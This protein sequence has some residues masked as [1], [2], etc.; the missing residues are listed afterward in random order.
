MLVYHSPT[1]S[2]VINNLFIDY[3]LSS[4]RQLKTK[5]LPLIVGGDM[6][7]NLLNPYN[8]GYINNFIHGMFELGL[9]PAV[10]IPTKVNKENSVTKFSIIDQF[11]VNSTLHVSNACV[12]PV[13]LTDHF[14][15]GLSIG[16]HS[17]GNRSDSRSNGRPLTDRGRILFRVLLKTFEE[18]F[19]WVLIFLILN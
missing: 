10:N 1:A 19:F 18:K 16:L 6:N 12:I 9:V 7:L 2:H 17:P 3:L 13:D 15:V 4:L 14:P 11:W 8:F 5:N